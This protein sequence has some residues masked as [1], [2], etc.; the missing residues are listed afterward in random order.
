ME[1][2]NLILCSCAC[3]PG[4]L[5]FQET[6]CRECKSNFM[7]TKH[8]CRIPKREVHPTPPRS[9][10]VPT[11][12]GARSLVAFPSLITALSSLWAPLSFCRVCVFS[13][14]LFLSLSLLLPHTA[15]SSL[16]FLSFCAHTLL[17]T[18]SLLLPLGSRPLTIPTRYPGRYTDAAIDAV[19]TPCLPAAPVLHPGVAQAAGGRRM[20]LQSPWCMATICSGGRARARRRD[21]ERERGGGFGLRTGEGRGGMLELQEEFIVSVLGDV[22]FR[23][24]TRSLS[25]YIFAVYKRR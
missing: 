11:E 3:P 13:F 6:H 8:L 1:C 25:T 22:K 7:H 9:P 16:P 10:N 4:L 19:T 18:D 15:A 24:R 12:G 20:S 21:R 2:L 5:V 14:S 17:H 23:R